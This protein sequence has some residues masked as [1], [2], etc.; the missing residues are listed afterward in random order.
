MNEMLNDV[1]NVPL[2]VMDLEWVGNSFTPSDTHLVDIACLNCANDARFSA[3]VKPL[4]SHASFT[5][6]RA[7]TVVLQEW[8]K[9]LHSQSNNG[10]LVL[11]AHNGIRFDAPVLLNALQ[12]CGLA[13]P[14]NVH[15]M[16]SLYHLR[17]HLRYRVPKD[18]KYDI[19]SLCTYF[20]V[21]VDAKR[22]HSASYDVYLLV[23]LLT[24]CAQNGMPFISG[25]RQPLHELSTMLVHGIGP[26]VSA[27]LPMSGLRSLCEAILE[28]HPNLES[29]SCASYLF[30][31]GLDVTLPL[32][33]ISVI[34]SSVKAAACKYLQYLETAV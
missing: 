19:D 29:T 23:Q 9:W 16:D 34:A 6:A 22:R 5:N 27:A 31:I 24:C 1:P 33:N 26:A 3:A 30:S 10:N 21:A 32:C 18:T 4:S 11:I 2:V 13:V 25:R 8:L 12:R 28:Q 17:H 15:V 14:T 7:A 20:G